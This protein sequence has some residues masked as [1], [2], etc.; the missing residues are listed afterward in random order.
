M[1]DVTRILSQIETGDP[2]ATG[3]L[4]TLVYEELRRLAAQQLARERP[5]QTLQAT[6]LVHEAYIRLVDAENAQHWGSRRHF[7]AAAAQAMRRILVEQA[8][9]KHREKHGG[10]RQRVPLNEAEPACDDKHEELL[11]VHEALDKLAAEDAEAAEL[12]QLRY[13]GGL[14]VEQ[15]AETMGIPRSTAY[16][17]WAYA[18]ASLRLLLDG[19]ADGSFHN[20][21]VRF[22]QSGDVC[23]MDM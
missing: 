17:R 12:V 14:S 2:Q 18:K 4:L 20:S 11:A 23:R 1:A 6:A 19:E 22:G 9:W 5:G 13:F 10:G 7:F 21:A 8:R 3:Q 16:A 15:A